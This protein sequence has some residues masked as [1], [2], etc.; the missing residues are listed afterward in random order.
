VSL[1]LGKEGGRALSLNIVLATYFTAPEELI[2]RR[3]SLGRRRGG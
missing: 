3:R 2:E 1:A